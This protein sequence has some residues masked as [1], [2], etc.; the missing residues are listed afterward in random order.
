MET[1]TGNKVKKI[2]S[3]NSTEYQSNQMEKFIKDRGIVIEASNPYTPQ[4]NGKAERMNRT[5]VE[6]ARCMIK[7]ANLSKKYWPYAV[8]A[9]AFVRN[10]LPTSSIDTKTT[11]EELFTGNRPEYIVCITKFSRFS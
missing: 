10:R 5:L 3:D 1:Q 8:M 7:N 9:A 2:T 4:Q 11:P 6:M